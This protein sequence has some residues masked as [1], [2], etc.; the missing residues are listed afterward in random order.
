MRLADRM[1]Q[2]IMDISLQ[3]TSTALRGTDTGRAVEAA[4]E[5]GQRWTEQYWEDWSP[6]C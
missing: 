5:T 6:T 3:T 1:P 2:L 4:G